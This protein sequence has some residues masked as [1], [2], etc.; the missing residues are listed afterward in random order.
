MIVIDFG[1]YG[2]VEIRKVTPLEAV[3]LVLL[4]VIVAWTLVSR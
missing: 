1:K 2:K 3:T 4:V